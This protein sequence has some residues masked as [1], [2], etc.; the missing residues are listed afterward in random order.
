MDVGRF[1][2]ERLLEDRSRKG[3]SHLCSIALLGFFFNK[4]ASPESPLKT[5]ISLLSTFCRGQRWRQRRVGCSL[6]RGRVPPLLR[7]SCRGR[8]GRRMV[9]PR[10]R[11]RRSRRSGR[12]VPED[13]AFARRVFLP[14]LAGLW[15]W[16]REEL[17]RIFP[18]S[19]TIAIDGVQNGFFAIE[20]ASKERRNTLRFPHEERG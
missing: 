11:R 6:R 20:C 17:E 7:P 5:S 8:L 12:F 16:V 4:S 14:V 2:V 10:R 3:C 1:R 18:D 19:R 13:R 15:A 9:P